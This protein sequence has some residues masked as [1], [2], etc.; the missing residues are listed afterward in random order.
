MP[1]LK[2]KP[3]LIFNYFLAKGFFFSSMKQLFRQLVATYSNPFQSKDR[4]RSHQ[5]LIN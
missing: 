5:S 4:E 3:A 1:R 2:Q